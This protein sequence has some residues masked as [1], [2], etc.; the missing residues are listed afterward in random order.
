[1]AQ[2]WIKLGRGV[3][4][5]NHPSETIIDPLDRRKRRPCRVFS[6]TYKLNGK[7]V[8]EGMGI[9]PETDEA[10]VLADALILSENRK[11]K[12]GPQTYGELKASRNAVYLEQ[13]KEEERARLN[14]FD[15]FFNTV[16]LPSK[17]TKML[18]GKLG[19]KY[20]NEIQG[21]NKRYLKEIIGHLAFSDITETHFDDIVQYMREPVEKRRRV[22]DYDLEDKLKA[23]YAAAGKYLRKTKYYKEVVTTEPRLSMTMV[24]DVRAL[25]HEVWKKAAKA[26]LADS[27]F[28]G[29]HIAQGVLNNGRTRFLSFDEIEMILDDLKR[30]SEDVYHYT[31][32]AAYS[33]LRISSILSLTW[34]AL[35]DQVARDTKNEENVSLA[36]FKAVKRLRDIIKERQEKFP[37]ASPK[38]FI[39][40][41]RDGEQQT[42]MSKTYS[43]CIEDLRFNRDVDDRRARVCFHTLRHSF[44]SLLI[45]R[46][47]SQEKVAS[48]LGHKDLQMTNRYTHLGT[49]HVEEVANVLNSL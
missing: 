22:R 31:A 28:P 15:T 25:A 33:G 39:F 3:R 48:M 38:D 46:D 21:L 34:G 16:F 17:R 20:Y 2:T 44:A 40:P 41:K 11:K 29:E 12:T 42:Q 43:R 19:E 27:V 13:K 26:K 47:V 5:Y 23:E 35:R 45:Q 4:Y 37:D 10:E 36:A 30:R 8:S 9:E 32:I 1:M 7:T 49:K 14:T 24:K 18:E 6:I